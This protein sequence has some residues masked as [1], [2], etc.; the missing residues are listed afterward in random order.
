MI[1]SSQLSALTGIRHG[2]HTRQ[3]GASD[4]LFASLN[5]GFGSGDN[6]AVVAHNRAKVAE[7]LAVDE[8]ALLT[9]WQSHSS[10]VVT[11]DRPWDVR[12]PPEGDAMVSA[13]PGIALGIL[14]ADCAPILFADAE[15][16]VIGAAHAGWKGAIAGITDATIA[17]MEQLGA[18]R[19]RI[20]AVIGPTI[21]QASYEVGP[22]LLSAFVSKSPENAAHFTHSPGHP[23]RHRFDLP[24]YLMAQL[25]MA[26]VGEAAQL[27]LDTYQDESSFFSYRRM[28]HRGEK[29]Y[30]RQISTIVLA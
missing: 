12:K 27:G 14:T 17:A 28:T 22:E 25:K 24:G 2:F 15:A 13:T 9:V 26:G 19:E 7:R 3:G 6:L 29:A 16:K 18:K 21:G 8:H 1:E 20:V 23:Q 4:G 10:D 11:V 30:G 5:C